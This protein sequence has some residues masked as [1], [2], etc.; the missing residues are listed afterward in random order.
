MMTNDMDEEQYAVFDEREKARI[1]ELHYQKKLMQSLVEKRLEQY[2]KS[3][4][5]REAA[6][7]RK[8]DV[9]TLGEYKSKKFMVDD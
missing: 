4:Q 1:D 5:E 2:K 6:R 3:K 8:I 7:K 9:N